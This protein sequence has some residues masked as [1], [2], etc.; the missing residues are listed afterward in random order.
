[1]VLI[2]D[3][4]SEHVAHAERKIGLFGEKQ[5]YVQEMEEWRKAKLR[6]RDGR[7]EKSKV[8]STRW[9]NEEKQSYVQGIEEWRK[10]NTRIEQSFCSFLSGSLQK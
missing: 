3:G 7:M 2:L 9:K 6:P 1:M 5:S 4:N 10:G 8:T